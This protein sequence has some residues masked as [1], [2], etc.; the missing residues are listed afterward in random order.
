[1]ITSEK[2]IRKDQDNEEGLELYG[3]Y[4]LLVYADVANILGEN[5][6]TIKKNTNCQRL[7]GRLV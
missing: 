4:K 7:L 2:S 6:N 5:K 3:T 1:L